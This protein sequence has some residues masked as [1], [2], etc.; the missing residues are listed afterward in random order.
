M[1]TRVA[2]IVVSTAL[3]AGVV[4]CSATT[5]S[6]WVHEPEPGGFAN[7][8][9]TVEVT[10]HPVEALVEPLAP[11]RTDELAQAP[12]PRPRLTRTITLGETLVAYTERAPEPRAADRSSVHVTVNNYVTPQNESDDG[13]YSGYYGGRFVRPSQPIA[14]TRPG[15]NWPAPKSYGPA[16][17]FKTA[18]ASPWAP[19]R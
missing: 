5:G 11:T 17:P 8:D 18:P 19:D 4:G 6:S 15:Q 3:L 2:R 14:P 12:S 1:V 7:D 10:G 16:F 9:A 13:Y